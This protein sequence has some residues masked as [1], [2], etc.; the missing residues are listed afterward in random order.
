MIADVLAPVA[1]AFFPTA[2]VVTATV[3]ARRP[4]QD[5]GAVR[6]EALK[7]VM[8]ADFRTALCAWSVWLLAVL[9]VGT[10]TAYPLFALFL[11]NT[12]LLPLAGLAFL[13][14]ITHGGCNLWSYSRSPMMFLLFPDGYSRF[15]L[16][17]DKKPATCFYV[18]TTGM[19]LGCCFLRYYSFAVATS[20]LQLSKCG[21]GTIDDTCEQAP[22]FLLAA[23][24]NKEFHGFDRCMETSPWWFAN[25][26]IVTG[27]TC[28]LF[29]SD[30]RWLQLA[31]D[32]VGSAAE[33]VYYTMAVLPVALPLV[34]LILW[35]AL[36]WLLSCV[37]PRAAPEG[38][39]RQQVEER[40]ASIEAEMADGTFKP[41][42]YSVGFLYMEFLLLVID[43][44]SDINCII[45][46]FA[47]ENH[48]AAGIIQ[49]VV[50]LLPVLLELCQ[51]RRFQPVVLW[52]EFNKSRRRGY[53]TAGFIRIV[54]AEK[55]LEAPLSC[56][57]QL[58]ILYRNTSPRA[59]LSCWLSILLSLLSTAHCAYE[60]FHLGMIDIIQPKEKSHCA[61]KD[62]GRCIPMCPTCLGRVPDT[63]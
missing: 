16:L 40:V 3:A 43:V 33:H 61:S 14:A 31:S 2:A 41:S 30:D 8:R 45:T 53:R 13:I 52:K 56:G 23:C 44:I 48:P 26:C 19:K 34:S 22:P 62:V 18:I 25:A 1:P 49:T 28:R 58:S 12:L 60:I 50:L 9:E 29:R 59:F 42:R 7:Q 47:I 37:L 20:S 35:L 39:W 15:G 51:T 46:F 24:Q 55:G 17:E 6:V 21:K 36:C 11:N 54:Q 38:G 57:F 27:S 5:G 63:E 32:A 4:L 10:C